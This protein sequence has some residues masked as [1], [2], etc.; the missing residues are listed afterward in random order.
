MITRF[1][2]ETATALATLL[3]GLIIVYGALEFG[4]GWDSSGP[5]PGAFPFYTGSIVAIASIGTL[6][7]TMVQRLRG[8]AIVSEIFLDRER[9]RRVVSF[10]LPLVAFV[11]ISHFAGMYVATIAYLVYAMHFQ[12]G[13]RWHVSIATAIGTAIIFYVVFERFFQIGLMKGPIEQMLGL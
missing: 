1:W 12:G 2:A 10:F 3:F 4:I 11:V 8:S 13:Y 7:V 6:V 9:L 5:Q